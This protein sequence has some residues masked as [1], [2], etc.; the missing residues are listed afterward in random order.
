MRAVISI[1]T[2]GLYLGASLLIFGRLR[3]LAS[4]VDADKTVLLSLW[5]AAIPLHAIV[6]YQHLI[7]P[8]GI[9]LKFFNALSIVAILLATLLLIS[10]VRRP[11]E[12]LGI[13]VLPAAALTVVL[14][15]FVKT[16]TVIAASAHSA[17]QIHILVSLLAYST[18]TLAA[19]QALV[20]AVQDHHL[21]A[22]HPGGLIRALPPLQVMEKLLFQLIALGFALLSLA[23]VTGFMFLEDLFA[24]HLVHKTL[25]S[26]VAWL[27]FAVLLWGRW[28]FGWRGR[29][30]IRGTLGGVLVLML[31]Y[32]GTKLVL[33][34]VL[35]VP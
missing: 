31:A 32:F 33:E 7:I 34:L 13:I 18:L 29:T 8:G 14:D 2:I 6:I 23:L 12:N 3:R 9:N 25:L 10:T 5:G 16:D 17:L 11:L 20:L 15:Q 27:V 1:L 35:Q 28:Q 19:L 30:A 24:Q 4:G 22:H 21:H 26:I